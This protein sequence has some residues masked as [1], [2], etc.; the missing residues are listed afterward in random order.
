MLHD[1]ALYRFNIDVDIDIDGLY[2]VT[3]GGDGL[4]RLL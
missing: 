4:R 1:I 3:H 2:F